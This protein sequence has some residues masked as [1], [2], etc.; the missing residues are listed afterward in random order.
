MCKQGVYIANRE[1]FYICLYIY[2]P[3]SR[4][5]GPLLPPLPTYPPRALALERDGE[6][7][8]ETE[9]CHACVCM[10]MHSHA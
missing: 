8:K 7:A 3:G 5:R 10:N 1:Y 4:V 2:V 6:K 9:A